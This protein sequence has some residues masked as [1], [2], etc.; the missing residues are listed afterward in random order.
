MWVMNGRLVR[1]GVCVKCRLFDVSSDSQGCGA[2][3]VP[4]AD[5]LSRDAAERRQDAAA[6]GDI[7][8]RT[9]PGY[10]ALWYTTH[11]NTPLHGTWRYGT[12]PIPTPPLQ[13]GLERPKPPE[14]LPNLRTG[15]C[16]CGNEPSGCIK[17]CKFLSS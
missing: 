14:N 4:A 16:I 13:F 3:R 11:T 15:C 6:F 2:F 5:G 7:S 12:R 17:C 10:M 9:M 8:C 1:H